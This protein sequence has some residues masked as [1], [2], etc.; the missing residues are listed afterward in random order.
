MIEKNFNPSTGKPLVPT[1]VALSKISR[2]M[3]LSLDEL[4]SS[5]EDMPVSLA[6]PS[7]MS[8]G[9]LDKE[10]YSLVSA[11]RKAP[12][13]DRRIVAA[14]LE[15]YGFVYTEDPPAASSAG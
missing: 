1:L 12:E 3:G 11:W 4:F 13:K 6:L 7:S 8:E 2:G 15:D 5:I 10:E 9:E 14:A